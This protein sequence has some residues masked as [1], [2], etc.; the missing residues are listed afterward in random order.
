MD[1]PGI[2]LLRA[3]KPLR[4]A[5]LVAA[6]ALIAAALLWEGGTRPAVVTLAPKQIAVVA[7]KL[8][9]LPLTNAALKTLTS[10]QVSAVSPTILGVPVADAG[11]EVPAPRQ[12]P[13]EA[14]AIPHRPV[15]SANPLVLTS[16]EI[17]VAAPGTLG[18]PRSSAHLAAV[19][20]REIAGKAPNILGFHS[21][22]ANLSPVPLDS[23]LEIKEPWD[24]LPPD[25]GA[26]FLFVP[27]VA[28][29]RVVIVRDEIGRVLDS[30]DAKSGSPLLRQYRLDP[31]TYE[32]NLKGFA[33]VVVTIKS[34]KRATIQLS[35]SG[36][37]VSYKRSQTWEPLVGPL[38]DSGSE[39]GP[40]SIS[41]AEKVLNF[42]AELPGR[43]QPDVHLSDSLNLR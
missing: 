1:L 42:T 43:H 10:K 11:L 25:K 34:G 24:V 35:Q 9:G 7:P 22:S 36:V 41:S 12:M 15:A 39:I 2:S 3:G 28:L 27:S 33:A 30:I 17:A 4:L 14:A 38:R 32:L 13:A 29:D 40:R 18:F 37:S 23:S 6:M 21:A 5:A 16:R 31:G 19:S 8:L 26:L 20:V